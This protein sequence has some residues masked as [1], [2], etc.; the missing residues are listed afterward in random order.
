MTLGVTLNCDPGREI[1]VFV[2]C[3]QTC[4][5]PTTI[6]VWFWVVGYVYSSENGRTPSEN[7][8]QLM[9]AAIRY[10]EQMAHM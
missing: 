8:H 4:I 2:G 5:L 6:Q 7:S 3:K 9:P 1:K 10:Q